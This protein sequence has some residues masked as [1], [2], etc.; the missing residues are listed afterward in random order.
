MNIQG[1]RRVSLVLFFAAAAKEKNKRKQVQR[2]SKGLPLIHSTVSTLRVDAHPNY[3]TIARY[4]HVGISPTD[5]QSVAAEMVLLA[6][7]AS[8]D[9]L[10]FDIIIA[11][12]VVHLAVSLS[13]SVSTSA[14][15]QP[16]TSNLDRG[17][18][19]QHVRLIRLPTEGRIRGPR[20]QRGQQAT[21][22]PQ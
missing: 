16:N 22:C 13:A 8:R 9:R 21:R 11:S 15:P 3:A 20:L 5:V 19:K 10:G 6:A 4:T 2:G 7:A 18:G 14:A 12:L 1:P 17:P